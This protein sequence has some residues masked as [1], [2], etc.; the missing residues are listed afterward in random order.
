MYRNSVSLE[1]GVFS[2]QPA[3]Y[4]FYH[5]FTGLLQLVAASFFDIFMLSDG[6]LLSVAYLWAQ[7]NRDTPVSFM[8]GLNFKV[9]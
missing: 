8:F 3:D 2:G 1:T 7:H 9:I 4:V 5:L 6:L